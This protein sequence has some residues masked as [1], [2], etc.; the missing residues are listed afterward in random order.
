MKFLSEEWLAK[1]EAKIR[2]SLTPGKA[3][4][5]MTELYKEC[6]DGTDK[7]IYYRIDKGLLA[8]IKMGV[9]ADTLPKAGFAGSGKY[10]SYVLSAKGEIDAVKA[11]S[12]GHFKFSGNLLKALP[13]YPIYAKVNEAKVF[14]DNEY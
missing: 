9:G 12:Q 7:W 4:V 1:H 2:E 3:C 11:I 6:P 8:E 10:S 14:P 13:M 5:E